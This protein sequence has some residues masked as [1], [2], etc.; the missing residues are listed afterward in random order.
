MCRQLQTAIHPGT[1]PP[2]PPFHRP[3]PHQRPR[4]SPPSKIDMCP[5]GGKMPG[6][7]KVMMPAG[8]RMGQFQKWGHRQ[9]CIKS[10]LPTS[11]NF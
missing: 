4:T 1:M 3:T 7:P 9:G 11:G 6:A 10:R 5:P 2:S 8:G